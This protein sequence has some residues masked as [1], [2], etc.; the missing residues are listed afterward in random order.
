MLGLDNLFRMCSLRRQKL[1]NEVHRIAEKTNGDY[2]VPGLK[3]RVRARSKVLTKYSDDIACL[4]DILRA[5][6]CYEGIEELY[7]GLR[8]ILEEDL[9]CNR[10]DFFIREVE[11]RFL[12]SKDGYRDMML[13]FEIDGVIAEVQLH[14]R[15]ILEAK[16]SGGHKAYRKERFVNELLFEA[17]LRNYEQELVALARHHK[18][19]ASG[20]RDRYSRTALHYAC[21]HGSAVAVR[22]LMKFNADPWAEDRDGILPCELALRAKHF[23]ALA[24]VLAQMY[25]T[26]PADARALRRLAEHSMMWWCD[27]TAYTQADLKTTEVVEDVSEAPNQDDD[28]EA[29]HQDDAS[30]ASPLCINKAFGSDWAYAGSLLRRVLQQHAE[31]GGERILDRWL[32]AAASAGQIG[33]VLAL[34]S[35]GFDV[36]VQ[37]GRAS[38]MD[39]SIEGGHVELAEKLYDIFTRDEKDCCVCWLR[40]VNEHL[41]EAAKEEDGPRA[42][43]A[44]KARADPNDIKSKSSGK[45]TALMAFSAAG[46]L[47]IVRRLVERQ[48]QVGYQDAFGNYALQYAKAFGHVEVQDYVESIKKCPDLP[49]H[50]LFQSKG[51]QI[52]EYLIEAVRAGCC[53]AHWRVATDDLTAGAFQELL[54]SHTGPHGYTLLHFAVQAVRENDPAGQVCRSLLMLRADGSAK[55][56]HGETPLHL[57][58]YEGS[59][60]LYKQMLLAIQMQAPD[61]TKHRLSEKLRG[62]DSELLAQDPH[63]LLSRKLAQKEAKTRERYAAERGAHTET[64]GDGRLLLEVGLLGLKHNLLASRIKAWREDSSRS[65]FQQLRKYQAGC[66]AE[67]GAGRSTVCDEGVITA[68]DS[69][70]AESA[71]DASEDA[72]A[73]PS[74]DGNED[75]LDRSRPSEGGQTWNKVQQVHGAFRA[76]HRVKGNSLRNSSSKRVLKLT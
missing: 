49:M 63:E 53:A 68:E 70:S 66:L 74:A 28:G 40:H 72:K 3:D 9:M 20:V 55:A 41:R 64:A 15:P 54:H 4:T 69:S 6:I 32:S 23:D 22:Y 37:S 26:Q 75:A 50:K 71:A 33:R 45:R 16:K 31:L 59:S 36:K 2:L 38:A 13:L 46:D 7:E 57:L 39:C 73:I 34:L 11:D 21:Q 60:G 8:T 5:S 29:P 67:L 35:S 43:A 62:L 61:E 44:L 56:K 10:C 25:D 76:L 52:K 18:T 30:S 58:A 51:T 27:H 12:K 24:L 1:T 14:C 42:L 48:A 17:C 47:P 19:S 65:G